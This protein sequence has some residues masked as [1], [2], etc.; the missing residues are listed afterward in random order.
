[1]SAIQWGF[2]VLE[3]QTLL[4]RKGILATTNKT[5]TSFRVHMFCTV[6]HLLVESVLHLLISIYYLYVSFLARARR[7]L[8][9]I[10]RNQRL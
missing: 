2:P 5:G 8:V 4:D 7:W 10:K 6:P 3:W 9:H 1:M